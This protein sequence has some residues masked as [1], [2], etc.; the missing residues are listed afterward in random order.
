MTQSQNRSDMLTGDC[1]MD[2]P[3]CPSAFSLQPNYLGSNPETNKNGSGGGAG[4]NRAKASAFPAACGG[5]SERII[6]KTAFLTVEDSLQLA[7]GNL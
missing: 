5:V 2:D 3:Y 7:A 6:K 4:V 1:A